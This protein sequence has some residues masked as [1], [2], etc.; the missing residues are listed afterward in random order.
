ML[1]PHGDI[2]PRGPGCRGIA[3]GR[4]PNARGL[5]RPHRLLPPCSHGGLGGLP[6]DQGTEEERAR[7]W[8]TG[9]S[10]H[11]RA[12]PESG[13]CSPSTPWGLVCV[14][15]LLPPK[16]TP[17]TSRGKQHKLAAL[18]GS[19]S[20]ARGGG[21]RALSRSVAG[22]S[23]GSWAASLLTRFLGRIHFLVVLRPT[24]LSSCAVWPEAILSPWRPCPSWLGLLSPPQGPQRGLVFLRSVS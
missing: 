4:G 19:E 12:P 14:D 8:C 9:G 21:G 3:G 13:R 10:A 15:L 22:G 11:T 17:Q 16:Q 6:C 23:P 18:S 5:T 7:A 2:G 1:S 24:S 20:S